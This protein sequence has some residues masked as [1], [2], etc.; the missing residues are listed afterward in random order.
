MTTEQ[1]SIRAFFAIDL[2]ES[3]KKLIADVIAELQKNTKRKAV[4]WTK[5]EHLHITLH[6][7]KEIKSEHVSKLI[8][9]VRTELLE[10]APFYLELGQLELFPTPYHPRII[11][12]NITSQEPLATL[13]KH[14]GRGIVATHYP[15]ET[16]PFRGHLTLG[17]LNQFG[18]YD[19]PLE[20]IS[21]PKSEKIL[22][23]EIILYRS[24]PTR[25]GSN[26]IVIE[27]I[28]LN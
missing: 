6:F 17:R 15:I 16:R 9:N 11:S 25:E 22:I 7:L 23:T 12:M 8:H 3:T 5:A 18:K 4:R 24:E 1:R 10:L 27:R 28:G 21:F 14:I 20:I 19:I 13:A 2:P 26:Y